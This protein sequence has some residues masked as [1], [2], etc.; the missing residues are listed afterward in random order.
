MDY[1]C[2][3]CGMHFTREKKG[4]GRPPSFCS[5]RC[6]NRFY[7]EKRGR[8]SYRSAANTM[9]C[10]VCRTE[11]WRSKS[12]LP[13]GRATC[14]PCRRARAETLNLAGLDNCRV[15]GKPLS[16]VQRRRGGQYCSSAC[17]YVHVLRINPE[18]YEQ[19]HKR[20][21]RFG[22]CRAVDE[23][24][25]LVIHGPGRRQHLSLHRYNDGRWTL[26]CRQC[27]N[28]MDIV[29]GQMVVQCDVCTLYTELDRPLEE[30]PNGSSP[31]P[32]RRSQDATA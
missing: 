16:D 3:Q 10:S 12:S 13:E 4:R 28:H 1:A 30:V 9:K 2:R 27:A 31:G 24:S 6:T 29:V 11:M 7:Y 26:C 22:V 5:Q 32:R 25:G 20:Y 17:G 21:R 8:Q 15:C 23:Q 18:P 19:E 14:Q